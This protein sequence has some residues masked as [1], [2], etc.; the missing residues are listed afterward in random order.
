MKAGSAEDVTGRGVVGSS[1]RGSAGS[2]QHAQLPH[3]G[4]PSR[5]QRQQLHR[6]HS[7]S[8]REGSQHAQSSPHAAPWG[9][10]EGSQH[11]QHAQPQQRAESHAGSEGGLLSPTTAQLGPSVFAQSPQQRPQLQ[12]PSYNPLRNVG[13]ATLSQIMGVGADHLASPPASGTALD[14]QAHALSAAGKSKSAP[15]DISVVR[16]AT[17]PLAAAPGPHDSSP[18]N[19]PGLSK[20]G[21]LLVRRAKTERRS[22]AAESAQEVLGGLHATH[23]SR[24]EEPGPRQQGSGELS[25]QGSMTRPFRRSSMSRGRDCAIM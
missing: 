19:Q 12:Q 8:S 18:P 9:S 6:L 20:S 2:S 21:F 16:A 4:S 24:K 22:K 14:H 1:D 11:A 10:R 25:E 23:P 7:S 13:Q 5:A 15:L 17:G 3:T